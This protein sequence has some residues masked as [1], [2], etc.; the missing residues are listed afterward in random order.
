MKNLR[1]VHIQDPFDY[2]YLFFPTLVTFV[3]KRS[4]SV[5]IFHGAVTVLLNP[6][7]CV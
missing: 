1:D 7:Q 4:P 2:R 6:S 5:S 3:K